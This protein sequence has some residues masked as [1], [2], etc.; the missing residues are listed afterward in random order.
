MTQKN[1][2]S[3]I[4]KQRVQLYRATPLKLQLVDELIKELKKCFGEHMNANGI[5][6]D[7]GSLKLK[8]NLSVRMIEIDPQV[9]GAVLIHWY[10]DFNVSTTSDPFCSAYILTPNE[11]RKLIK[12]VQ[13][14][15]NLR[16]KHINM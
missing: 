8:D 10:P 13:D 3:E 5:R 11:L 4:Q 12:A 7:S 16:E 6:L 15:S 9:I 14:V 2:L 1:K